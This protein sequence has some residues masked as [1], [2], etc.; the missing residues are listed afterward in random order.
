MADRA[1]ESDVDSKQ[2][3]TMAGVPVQYPPLCP[4]RGSVRLLAP[5]LGTTAGVTPHWYLPGSVVCGSSSLSPQDTASPAIPTTISRWMDRVKESLMGC[6]DGLSLGFGHVAID[7]IGDKF[8]L[9][10]PRALRPRSSLCSRSCVARASLRGP[11]RQTPHRYGRFESRK[12]LFIGLRRET[13]NRGCCTRRRRTSCP[14][15]PPR[16]CRGWPGAGL[17]A[18]RGPAAVREAR[19]AFIS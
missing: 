12:C 11:H 1:V 17:P 13:I 7:Q 3:G 16:L 10:R 8:N 9:A 6:I 18:A 15:E 14:V 19:W 2:I 5:L 4:Y